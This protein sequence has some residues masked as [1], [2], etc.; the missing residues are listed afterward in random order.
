[1]KSMEIMSDFLASEPHREAH[2]EDGWGL[3]NHSTLQIQ[4]I[5]GL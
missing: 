2:G 4:F 1:M 3:G 5:A